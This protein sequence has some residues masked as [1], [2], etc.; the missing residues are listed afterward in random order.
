[1]TNFNFLFLYLKKLNVHINKKE[2]IIQYESHPAYPSLL[3]VS[4]TLNFFNIENGA[5]H[6]EA[7]EIS[8]LPSVFMTK[9]KDVSNDTLAFVETKKNGNSYTIYANSKKQHISK[10]TLLSQWKGMVFLIEN[11][12]GKAYKKQQFTLIHILM[13][14]CFFSLLLLFRETISTLP[15]FILWFL[16]IFGF[17]FS[18]LALQNIFNFDS[19]LKDVVCKSNHEFS[20]CDAVLHSSEKSSILSDVSIVF[21]SY[22]FISFLIATYTNTFEAYFFIQKLA[23]F[24]ALPI[25]VFSIY[26]QVIKIKKRCRICIAISAIIL[27]ELAIILSF[28]EDISFQQIPFFQYNFHVFIFLFLLVGWHFLKNTLRSNKEM[29]VTIVHANRF[30]RN[31]TVFRNTLISTPK[32]ALPQTCL[33]FG[34]PNA[35]II[36]DFITNPYC[37]FCKK[38]TEFLR[39][40]L[41][42]HKKDIAIRFIYNVNFNNREETSK[43]FLNQLIYIHKDSG[44]EAFFEALDFWYHTK[45]EQ[46]WLEMYPYNFD[47]EEMKNMLQS[48]RLWCIEN[49]FTFTPAIFINGHSFPKPYK[50]EELIYFIDDLIEDTTILKKAEVEKLIE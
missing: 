31:Y 50:I 38:P 42:K 7:A 11:N 3:A 40:L 33:T 46:K 39:K 10:S 15:Y 28:Q 12:V 22:Q 47:S 48:Q 20:G 14:S 29:K 43:Q 4:D 23:L 37:G 41:K 25:L 6:V 21:F 24:A 16:S 30:K 44:G 49:K 1:M 45:D 26:Y 34:N 5:I 9:L 17:G 13:I 19:S 8:A 32:V 18:L 35:K 36:L 2:F 27:S